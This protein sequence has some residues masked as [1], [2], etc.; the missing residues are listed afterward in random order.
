MNRPMSYEEFIDTAQKEH[1]L[2]IDK[3]NEQGQLSEEGLKEIREIK[4]TVNISVFS[5]TRCKDAATVIPFLMKLIDLNEK[6]K[7]A[8]YRKEGNEELLKKMTGENRIPTIVI[9]DHKGNPKRYYVEFPKKLKEKLKNSPSEE[10]QSI[11]NDMR[12]GKYNNF[13]QEDLISLL[14]GNNYEYIS[15]KRKD[16]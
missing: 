7:V 1:R 14:T 13:I 2:F 10:T 4:E 16:N 12:D 6:L 15:F 5:E 9:L 3:L 11:I 8:F